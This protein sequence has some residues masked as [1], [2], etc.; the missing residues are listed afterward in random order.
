ML[1]LPFSIFT[2]NHR[3]GPAEVPLQAPSFHGRET[4]TRCMV[5]LGQ[6]AKGGLDLLEPTTRAGAGTCA[7]FDGISAALG[8]DARKNAIV[9]QLIAAPNRTHKPPP[10]APT[11]AGPSTTT[12]PDQTP[13]TPVEPRH[14]EPRLVVSQLPDDIAAAAAANNRGIGED[15]A[16]QW[17]HLCKNLIKA[18]G[19]QVVAIVPVVPMAKAVLHACDTG[20]SYTADEFLSGHTALPLHPD[21]IGGLLPLRQCTLHRTP[22]ASWVIDGCLQLDWKL[23]AVP[24]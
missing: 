4:P 5:L 22:L 12:T 23:L 13:T 18:E 16:R 20:G 15:V 7:V 8:M 24:L 19:T 10:S 3:C 1:N 11:A 9:F 17:V 2:L 6:Q 21:L 14:P